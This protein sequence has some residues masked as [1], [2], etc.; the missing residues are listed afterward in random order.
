M[1]K[2]RVLIV[3]DDTLT[4]L[5]VK[6]AL[7]AAGYEVC[8]MAESEAE[9]LALADAAPP[10]FAVVDIALSPGDG[11]T[12]ARMLSQRHGTEVLFATGQCDEVSRLTRSGALACLPKPYDAED[13][14]TALEAIANIS[15]GKPPGRM[16]DHMFALNAV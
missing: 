16:P 7:I 15:C 12:V 6:D 3:E 10:D 13:V 11:R 8:G 9:A 2:A 5:D 1:A 14:P 4:A